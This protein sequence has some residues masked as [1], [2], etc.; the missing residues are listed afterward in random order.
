MLY[1][2]N[3]QSVKIER[4]GK[5]ATRSGLS[6]MTAMATAA[7]AYAEPSYRLFPSQNPVLLECG[8]LTQCHSLKLAFANDAAL[9]FFS[10]CA[11]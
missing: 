10:S 4:D 5:R 3:D 8:F 7:N 11:N 2:K 9:D 1:T 6:W